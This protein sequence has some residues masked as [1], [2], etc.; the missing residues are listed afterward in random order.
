[1]N[2]P[3]LLMRLRVYDR[4]HRI[5]LWIPLFLLFPI[6]LAIAIILT[7]L[8]LIAVIL[9]WPFGWGRPAL[10]LGPTVARCLCALRGLEVDVK[11]GKELVLISFK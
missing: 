11:E 10:V 5:G 6:V 7:P 1:M 4:R 3:P 8:V 9:L 2:W